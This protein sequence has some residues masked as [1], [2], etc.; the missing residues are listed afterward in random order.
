MKISGPASG[1]TF[2][3][4]FILSCTLTNLMRKVLFSVIVASSFL[5]AHSQRNFSLSASGNFS[6]LVRGSGLNNGGFGINI[7]SNLFTKNKLQLRAEASIDQFLGG[8]LL[9]E[10]SLGNPYNSN[11]AILSFKAG[12]VYFVTKNTSIAALYGYC[13]YN[14]FGDN[15]RSDS[16]KFVLTTR[17]RQHPRLLIGCSFTKMTGVNDDIHFCGVNVGYKIL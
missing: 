16:F 8:K 4:I 5:N 1:G 17:P 6:F 10:D 11:P 12:P 2:I 13:R 9:M 3:F 14:Y 7:H 15:Y